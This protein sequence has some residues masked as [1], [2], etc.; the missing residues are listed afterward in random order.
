[1]LYPTWKIDKH[2][3][4]SG[5]IDVNSRPYFEEDFS[6]QGYGVTT[7]ILFN[8]LSPVTIDTPARSML[9]GAMPRRQRLLSPVRS[10]A[11]RWVLR[12]RLR[13]WRCFWLRMNRAL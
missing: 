5:A 6:T 8:I 12:M 11:A 13:M 10:L 7:R 4:I 9:W 2:W 3:T 1:M